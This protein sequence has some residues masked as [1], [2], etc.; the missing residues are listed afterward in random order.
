V[1][2]K[3]WNFGSGFNITLYRLEQNRFRKTRFPIF[4]RPWIKV[5]KRYS[6]ANT[7]PPK[8]ECDFGAALQVLSFFARQIMPANVAQM[9]CPA[10]G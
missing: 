6:I 5:F 1:Y 10:L 7:A 8:A 2:D 4:W 9:T 3:A